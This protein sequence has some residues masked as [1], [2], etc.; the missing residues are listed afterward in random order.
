M[1]RKTLLSEGEIR[2][3]MKLAKIPALTEDKMQE[4][5]G[6]HSVVGDRDEE[7]EL[8]D[9]LHAT[10]DELGAEDHEADMEADEID[11]LEGDM[12]MDAAADS[13]E[14]PEELVMDLLSV[15]EDWA[16]GVGVDMD[17]EGDE[18]EEEV[19]DMEADVELG[20]VDDEVEMAGEEEVELEEPMM[21]KKAGKD[22]H[23]TG[24]H[25]DQMGAKD[26]DEDYGS[27]R[28]GE[29]LKKGSGKRGSKPGDEAYVNEEEVSLSEED[30]IVAE[31]ARRVAARL[32][33][34]QNREQL[35][36][37]IAERI[38]QRFTSK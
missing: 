5:Y 8:E 1:A 24:D 7:D 3:F 22:W 38:L 13:L 37:K 31:V 4:M 9:E 21:E 17:V 33:A 36:E 15:I 27:P 29:K 12:D 23:A 35:S 20:G 34:Q 26:K 18:G 10:E 2:Q 16:A 11:D 14:T 6:D 25:K 28:K 32:Q 30:E 19:V